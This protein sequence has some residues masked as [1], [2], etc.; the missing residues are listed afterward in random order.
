LPPSFIDYALSRK[1]ADGVFITGCR[2]NA[3][4]HRFG[5]TWTEA[6]LAAT[7][8]PYLRA[9]VPRERLAVHWGGAHDRTALIAALEEFRAGLA[10]LAPAPAGR[11]ALAR[12][13]GE[14]GPTHG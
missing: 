9:R 3:C 13:A 10:S 12:V 6:R 14:A 4:F 5:I 7:R 2:A 8:D 11:P 1:V